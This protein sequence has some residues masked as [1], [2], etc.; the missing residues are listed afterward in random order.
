MT[1]NANMKEPL[2][3]RL[4]MEEYVDFIASSL[5]EMDP[6]R[7]ERQKQLEENIEKPF[8]LSDERPGNLKSLKEKPDSAAC[9]R[10]KGNWKPF[11]LK[12]HE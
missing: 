5:R 11:T 8:S 4:S 2:P 12:D 9:V 3:P 6:A 7:I 10:E 1:S